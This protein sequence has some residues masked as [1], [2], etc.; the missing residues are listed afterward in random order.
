M[1]SKLAQPLRQSPLTECF[2]GLTTFY[3]GRE[4]GTSAKRT[5]GGLNV[6]SPRRA[7]LSSTGRSSQSP[8]NFHSRRA[9]SSDTSTL[10]PSP[11]WSLS[12][13]QNTFTQQRC[14]SGRRRNMG[15]KKQVKEEK[16]L[17][18][19]PG[20]N[21]KSGIVRYYRTQ[22]TTDGAYK[23]LMGIDLGVGGARKCRQINALSG[24][25]EMLAGQ[26]CSRSFSGPHK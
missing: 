23:M 2:V 9:G 26:S 6:S 11:P 24:N 4:G 25:H 15:P 19:R 12:L 18:G 17:L 7:K 8:Q 16:I 20:N 22:K 1:R 5:F 10:N 13:P 21:L 14:Y 3:F